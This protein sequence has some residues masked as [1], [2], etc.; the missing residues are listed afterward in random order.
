M[1]GASDLCVDRNPKDG[2]MDDVNSNSKM[3]RADAQWLA[4]FIK[5]ISG[6][7]AFEH[8]NVGLGVYGENPDHGPFV[9]M[10]VRGGRARW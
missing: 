6:G 7:G 1:G 5:E 4:D 2:V 9:H 10:D 3:N 8:R